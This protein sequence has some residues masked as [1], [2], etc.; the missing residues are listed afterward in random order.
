MKRLRA[1][2]HQQSAAAAQVGEGVLNPAGAAQEK[3][4][5]PAAAAVSPASTEPS[6]GM[7]TIN[8]EASSSRCNGESSATQT[9]DEQN[10]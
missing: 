8:A 9:G 2:E 4:Q 1:P 3:T 10:G 6:A 7:E 5:A